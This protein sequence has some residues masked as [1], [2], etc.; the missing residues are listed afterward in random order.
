MGKKEM[1]GLKKLRHD[2]QEPVSRF[3]MYKSGTQWLVAGVTTV[4]MA[5]GVMT[6]GHVTQVQAS[7]TNSTTTV[8]SGAASDAT[9]SSAVSAASSATSSAAP[10]SSTAANTVASNATSSAVAN[11]AASAATSSAAISSATLTSSIASSTPASSTAS[12]AT[13]SAA[14]SAAPT[15]AATTDK[16]AQRYLG[17]RSATAAAASSAASTLRASAVTSAASDV[18]TTGTIGTAAYNALKNVSEPTLV[19]TT[20]SNKAQTPAIVTKD[21]AI[22]YLMGVSDNTATR[23]T[24]ISDMTQLIASS[25]SLVTTGMQDQYSVYATNTR[26]VDGVRSLTSQS[27]VT[28][29]VYPQ[30]FSYIKGSEMAALQVHA[31][32]LGNDNKIYVA[33]PSSQDYSTLTVLD[34]KTGNWINNSIQ[35]LS[36]ADGTFKTKQILTQT[37]AT[38][39]F[40][41]DKV[42]TALDQS[43]DPANITGY[44]INLYSDAWTNNTRNSNRPWTNYVV[45]VLP[46]T[47]IALA[48]AI[49]ARDD[50]A[51]TLKGTGTAVGD[52]ITVLSKDGAGYVQ[53]TVG[54]DGTWSVN[55]TSLGAKYLYAIESNQLGDTPG[56]VGAPQYRDTTET[57]HYVN[58]LTGAVVHDPTTVTMHVAQNTL[59]KT[60]DATKLQTALNNLATTKSATT[61]TA[62]LTMTTDPWYDLNDSADTNFD[63][64]ASA[65]LPTVTGLTA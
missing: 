30:N 64:I 12:A 39:D 57:V 7:T 21:G 25:S 4:L 36:I 20:N 34:G 51:H 40:D 55:T 44:V 56:V 59:A 35:T 5:T 58:A 29:T 54:T 27:V 15:S 24:T 9:N 6:F 42:S 32:A 47:H 8:A 65:D 2:C 45:N 31:Y 14:S 22:A 33:Q 46:F 10:A 49:T 16:A 50:T 61:L 11:I 18:S 52:T 43:I 28:V 23:A 1:H 63:A 26:V 41:A 17:A 37:L 13:S 48:P 38:S 60:T 62:L 3:K 19:G 53:T